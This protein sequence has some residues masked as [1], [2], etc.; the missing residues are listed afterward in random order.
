MTEN[1]AVDMFKVPLLH[2]KIGDWEN[3]KPILLNMMSKSF[4]YHTQKNNSIAGTDNIAIELFLKDELNSFASYFNFKA[5]RVT[6]SWFQTAE[7]GDYHG[8]HNHSCIG[9]SSICYIDYDQDLH[10]STEF[11]SP[12]NNF[13]T[14]ES[15]HYSPKV[16]EGS[17]VFFPSSIL[18]YAN[19]NK[20]TK[21]RSIL[22]FNIAIKND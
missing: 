2:L 16:D 4:D 14:G 6:M 20:S 18:H 8:P 11:I 19:P 15:I 12:F 7:A 3:K 22:S 5:Y 9:Y 13:L 1:Y 17:I 21:S 10:S